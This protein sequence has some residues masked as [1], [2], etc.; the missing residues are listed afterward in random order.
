MELNSRNKMKCTRR[1]DPLVIANK[2]LEVTDPNISL[3]QVI[4]SSRFFLKFLLCFD[5]YKYILF[6]LYSNHLNGEYDI[7]K[8][9]KMAMKKLN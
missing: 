8:L 2:P 7:I 6:V 5:D 9:I 4:V 1:K 3:R